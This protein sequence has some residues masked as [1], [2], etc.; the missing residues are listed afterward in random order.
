MRDTVQDLRVQGVR[1]A[2]CKKYEV[3]VVPDLKGQGECNG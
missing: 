3:R 1:S 2:G